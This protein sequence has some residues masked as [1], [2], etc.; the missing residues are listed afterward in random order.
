[1]ISNSKNQNNDFVDNAMLMIHLVWCLIPLMFF[2]EV[3]IIN[4]KI[5]LYISNYFSNIFPN[6][7][8]IAKS[9]ENIELYNFTKLQISFSIIAI[10]LSFI[11]FLY[12]FLNV[13]WVSLFFVKKDNVN[14]SE[15][16][17][18]E[19]TLF[20]KKNLLF[21]LIIYL[22]ILDKYLFG[23]F[24]SPYDDTTS[25][26][27]F[28]HSTEIGIFLFSLI[29]STVVAGLSA[30][31]ILEGIAHSLKCFKEYNIEDQSPLS[32]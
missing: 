32:K 2:F 5:L 29:A 13:Y 11:S 1:M 4:N 15:S 18:N 6:I 14:F 23:W 10:P 24:S 9:S 16:I 7:E 26:L 8:K 20:P 3:D 28:L 31:L 19:K 27:Y 21:F 12:T 22:Y 17:Y 30:I 25:I